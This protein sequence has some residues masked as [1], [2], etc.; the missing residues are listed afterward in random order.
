MDFWTNTYAVRGDPYAYLRL[1]AQ[2][3]RMEIPLSGG[4]IELQEIKTLNQFEKLGKQEKALDYAEELN[5]KFA[6]RGTVKM[7]KNSEGQWMRSTAK[8]RQLDNAMKLDKMGGY[9]R[10][11][12]VE[13]TQKRVYNMDEEMPSDAQLDFKSLDDVPEIGAE[14]EHKYDDLDLDDLDEMEG[15]ELGEEAEMDALEEEWVEA[16]GENM[17]PIAEDALIEAEEAE[18]LIVLA[19]Q[20]ALVAVEAAEEITE[21]TVMGVLGSMAGGLLS[22]HRWSAAS[23]VDQETA[24]G[25]DLGRRAAAR[26]DRVLRHRQDD[27]PDVD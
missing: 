17:A 2:G 11:K 9:E 27:V 25:Q 12:G 13:M 21:V 3:S 7:V 14:I 16:F 4:A 23:E 8:S 1:T 5:T 10:P 18:D 20:V 22:A 15:P 24:P 26:R 19:R 6:S